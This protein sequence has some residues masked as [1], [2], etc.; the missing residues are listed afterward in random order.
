MPPVSGI[1]IYKS[2]KF[3]FYHIFRSLIYD[4]T[5]NVYDLIF[6]ISVKT[7]PN[8]DPNPKKNEPNPKDSKK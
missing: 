8:S 3:G 6:V 4:A 1:V 2:V 7:K 5:L